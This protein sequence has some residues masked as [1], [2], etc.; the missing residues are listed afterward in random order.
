[1]EITGLSAFMALCITTEIWD[2]RSTRSWFSLAAS[3]SSAWPD[4]VW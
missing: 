1:M 2:Q 3:R 4:P